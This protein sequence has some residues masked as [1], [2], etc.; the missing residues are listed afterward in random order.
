ME[1]DLLQFLEGSAENIFV[2]GIVLIFTL[3]IVIVT[4]EMGHYFAARLCGVRIDK[5]AFG[6]GRELFGVGGREEGQ[7]RW[8]F[9]IF[10]VGGYVKIF[11]DVDPKNPVIWDEKIDAARPLTKTEEQQAFYT[12]N[13]FQRM[14]IVVAGPAVNIFITLA[15][16]ISVFTFY[17]QSSKSV[18]INSIV[19]GSA[20]DLAGVQ[21]GDQ[22]VSMDGKKIRR[23]EDIYN[24]TRYTI[25]PVPA[26][27]GVIRDG[28]ALDIT[29]TPRH[30]VYE[31]HKGVP[32]SHGR[33]GMLRIYSIDIKEARVIDGIDVASA[34]QAR[35]IILS[36]LDKEIGVRSTFKN[37]TDKIMD[38][39][40]RMVLSSKDNQHLLDPSSEDYDYAFVVPPD[41][42]YYVKLPI[43]E[44]VSQT[45]FMLRNG[46]VNSYKLIK[47]AIQ[48]KND[49]RIIGGV[50]KLS[51]YAGESFKGGFY[52]FI[53]AFAIFNFMIGI[54]NL[55]PIP[56]LDG[57]YLVFFTWE[58][59]TGNPISQKIQSITLVMGLALLWGIMVFA[60]VG[61]VIYFLNDH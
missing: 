29:F 10:P 32:M 46:L 44:A 35:Q 14:F 39:T 42:E 61:D 4:H 57:G 30:M 47:A 55:L 52:S 20:A 53:M 23:L 38:D 27:Y 9:C 1:F 15:V 58:A 22:I 56:G 2:Y 26:T 16:F 11:G 60:N 40:F 31:N 24:K 54:V 7:T 3:A 21:V 37:K 13:V 6:F 49:E 43:E 33:T 8:S 17:G 18:T 36:K 25:P 5:F 34:E 50:G 41:E 12:R 28:K 45:F 19:N 51:Q 48:G 59:I